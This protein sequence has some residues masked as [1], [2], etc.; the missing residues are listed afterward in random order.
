M[1]SVPYY[2]TKGCKSS[3]GIW[4]G[5]HLGQ[6]ISDMVC[7]GERSHEESVRLGLVGVRHGFLSWKGLFPHGRA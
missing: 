5:F 1:P 2:A 7:A 4:R 3:R 6:G